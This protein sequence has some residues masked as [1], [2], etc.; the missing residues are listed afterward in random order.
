LP[1]ENFSPLLMTNSRLVGIESFCRGNRRDA[2]VAVSAATGAIAWRSRFFPDEFSPTVPGAGRHVVVLPGA[3]HGVVARD[4]R[5]GR[6][7]WRRSDRESAADGTTVAVLDQV[8]KTTMRVYALDRR[9]GQ[10]RWERSVPVERRAF[11]LVSAG[12][13]VVAITTATTS[14]GYDARTGARRWTIPIGPASDTMA[15][16]FQDGVV[17]GVTGIGPRG[18]DIRAYDGTTGRLLWTRHATPVQQPEPT[19]HNFY[20]NTS[21]G[22]SR[23]LALDARTGAV[24]WSRAASEF[25]F[26][27]PKTVVLPTGRSL[28]GVKS[29]SGSFRWRV[30]SNR[31]ARLAGQSG[32]SAV[33]EG[34]QPN[35]QRLFLSFG[36]C[37]GSD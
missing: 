34:L 26:A 35:R 17:S 33:L 1:D 5:T 14:T 36:N 10:Q 32:T 19:D 20:A 6:V 11:P 31:L 27:G 2:I 28:V 7:L 8:T 29:R 37:L 30:R 18:N 4:I 23:F 12:G 3:H 21:S 13:S 9:T 24:R 16:G 22:R 25:G 15:L